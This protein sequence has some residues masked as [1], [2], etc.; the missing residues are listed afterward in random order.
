MG[1][2]CLLAFIAGA[3]LPGLAY[4]AGD[5][6]DANKPTIKDRKFDQI[7]NHT[8]GI[9]EGISALSCLLASSSWLILNK[10]AHSQA[11]KIQKRF[12]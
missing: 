3:G 1:F 5:L 10:F 6:I 8:F 12:F 4:F 7:L 9:L 2:G 11:L